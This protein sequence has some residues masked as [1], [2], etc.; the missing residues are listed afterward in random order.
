MGDSNSPAPRLVTAD[1]KQIQLRPYDLESILPPDHRARAVWAIVE[2]LELSAFYDRIKARGSEPGRSATDP[3]VLVALWLYAT[4]EGVGAARELERL[5]GEHRAYQWLR[6]GV[7]VNYHTLSD[8]RVQHGAALDELLTQVLAV[9]L[10]EKLI[11][12]KRVSQD[13]LRVRA[14]AGAE[15]FRRRKRLKDYLKMARRQVEAVKRD[16]ED[17]ELTARQRAAAQRVARQRVERLERALVEL[18]KVETARSQQTG[19]KKAKSEP[20]ASMTDPEARKM[21]MGDGGF[22]P[23]YNVQLATET[24]SNMIVGV[25]VTNS[26]TDQGEA[27]PM[28]EQIEK[29]T[30]DRPEEYLV[31]GG[32]TGKATVEGASEL[33]VTL[34]GP[35]VERWGQDPFAPKLTDSVA[36]AEWRKRMGTTQA[37]E[38][39]RDRA[40]YSERVNADVKTQRTLDRMLVRGTN[41]VLCVALWNALA[42]NILRWITLATSV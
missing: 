9:L 22:R 11:S 4:A 31:D 28:I 29:R 27:L 20:R 12:L 5:C 40:Q 37:Q 33:G 6:G 38:I 26:G 30:G 39:Y 8:F 16:A 1:R 10:S 13:G 42:Y 24:K 19:G 2:R 34:Y 15:S 23:G 14:S 3:K 7:P 21:R 17:A 32:Y 35:V 36:L 25:A 18:G 41:K